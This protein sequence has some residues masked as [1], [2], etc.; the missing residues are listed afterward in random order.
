MQNL[1]NAS[2]VNEAPLSVDNLLGSPYYDISC[3][4]FCIM[5]SADSEVVLKIKGYLLEVSAIIKYP[6]LLCLKKL[7]ARSCHGL[8]GMS[9]SS[10]SCMAYVALN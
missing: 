10:I 7:A 1:A 8:S 4:N 6:A 9:L 2:K 5:L 3:L